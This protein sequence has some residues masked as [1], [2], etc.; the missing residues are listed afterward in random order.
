MQLECEKI[1]IHKHKRAAGPASKQQAEEKP[2]QRA[3]DITFYARC[4]YPT[5]SVHKK[6]CFS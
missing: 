4:H 6:M 5:S 3:C 1:C 2:T